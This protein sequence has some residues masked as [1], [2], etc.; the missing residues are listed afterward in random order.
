MESAVSVPRAINSVLLLNGVRSFHTEERSLLYFSCERAS[1]SFFNS[2]P[3]LRLHKR[4]FRF[5]NIP[6]VMGSRIRPMKVDVR[7][8]V[9]EDSRELQ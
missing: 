2:R 7:V 3:T 5:L 4:V 6:D 9:L 8:L 1:G